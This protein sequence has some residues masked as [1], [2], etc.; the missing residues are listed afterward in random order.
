MKFI[1]IHNLKNM[2]SYV[3]V[4][5]I[6]MITSANVGTYIYFTSSEEPITVKETATEIIGMIEEDENAEE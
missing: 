6:D 5:N 2:V 3:N 1:K 4:E